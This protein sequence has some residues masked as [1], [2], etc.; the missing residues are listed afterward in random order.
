M[1]LAIPNLLQG[2][3]LKTVLGNACRPRIANRWPSLLCAMLP[4]LFVC[5]VLSARTPDPDLRNAPVEGGVFCANEVAALDRGEPVVKGIR[6]NDPRDISLY[7]EI[8]IPSDPESALKAFQLSLYLKEKSITQSGK[9]SAV[10]REEDLGSLTLSDNDIADLKKCTV[11]DC[12]LRLSATMIE[13]FQK[14]IDWNASD[15]SERVNQLFRL[16]LVEYLTAYLRKGDDALIEY[17]DQNPTVELSREQESLLAKLLYVNDTTPEFMR[18][19]KT[20][21]GSS[22]PV[23]RSLSWAK[24]S[25]G[26]KPVVVIT[27]TS[28]YRSDIGG[29]R[30]VMVLSKQIYANHYFDASLS[31]TAAIGDYTHT[32]SNLLYVNHSRSAALAGSLTKIKHQVVER[33]A[34][35]ALKNLLGQTRLN[36]DVVL[37]NSSPAVQPGWTQWISES[38][39]LRLTFL[40]LLLL[41]IARIAGYLAFRSRMPRLKRPASS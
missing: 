36:V 12:K 11:G 7:G 33:R 27:D 13:R 24:M 35:E 3:F 26:L 22:M 23:E 8:T 16:M 25:F 30:R 5:H 31:L 20:L 18:D 34:T 9:F 2:I 10:P 32:N 39:A 21:L 29:I 14:D 4:L 6:S 19:L 40:L 37:S 28:T 15:Y 38:R 17:A 41:V 1:R